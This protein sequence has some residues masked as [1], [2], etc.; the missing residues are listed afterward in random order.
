MIDIGA[1]VYGVVPNA[2]VAAIAVGLIRNVIGWLIN[3]LEDGQI[4]TFEVKQLV[5]TVA[6]YIQYVMAFSIGM[7]V[8]TAAIAAFSL[9]VVKN[10]YEKYKKE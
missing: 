3:A 8:E 7:P 9:D 10:T 4:T 1:Y 5:K 6:T 2:M